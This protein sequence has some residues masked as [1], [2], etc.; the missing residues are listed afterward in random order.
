MDRDSAEADFKRV[1]QSGEFLACQFLPP[2]FFMHAVIPSEPEIYLNDTMVAATV[3]SLCP[4]RR[5]CEVLGKG[6]E[7]GM[8][9]GV[10]RENGN[11]WRR[12]YKGDFPNRSQKD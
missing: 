4:L 12:C 5:Q 10:S 1:A 6:E 9:G 2:S 7:Y 3:C 11:N 8:W